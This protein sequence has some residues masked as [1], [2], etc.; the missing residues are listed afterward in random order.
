MLMDSV[1]QEFEK[2]AVEM[3]FLCSMMTVTSA[4]KTL[5][6]GITQGPGSGII[7]SLI[8]TQD[9]QFTLSDRWDLGRTC[10]LGHLHMSSPCGCLRFLIT[11]RL[12]PRVS[13]AKACAFL[14]VALDVP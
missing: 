6:S 13:K 7:K 5:R 10:Q 3:A 8:H 4:G 1:G 11:W 2:D 14:S 12:L 9:W